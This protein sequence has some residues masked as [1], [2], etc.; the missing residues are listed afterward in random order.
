MV[1]ITHFYTLAGHQHHERL[2]LRFFVVGYD[3]IHACRG[4]LDSLGEAVEW[5]EIEVIGFL[6][7][8][9]PFIPLNSLKIF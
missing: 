5:G 7:F 2:G 1:G 6:Y 9:L 3:C 8:A 4:G